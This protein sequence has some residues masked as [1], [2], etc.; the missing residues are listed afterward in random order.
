MSAADPDM[1][2]PIERT[3]VLAF[4]MDDTLFPEFDYVFSGFRA[5]DLWLRRKREVLGFAEAAAE[6]YAMG[7]RGTVFDHAL[8][9]MGVDEDKNL[10]A[11]MVQVYR[12]HNPDIHLDSRTQA[13]LKALSARAVLCLISDGPLCSQRAKAAALGLDGL[14]DH[15]RCTDEWGREFWKPSPRAFEEVAALHPMPTPSCYAYIG[16]NPSKD[17]V[18]PRKM[19][20]HS[21]RFIRNRGMHEHDSAPSTDHEPDSVIHG[22]DDLPDALR[23][24]GMDV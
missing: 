24:L 14:F 16:D 9:V 2:P 21:V 17:F 10:V 11:E 12:C 13:V 18:I 3:C 22:M 8:N 7:V 1:P 5:V 15:I 4:D 20:W 23:A 6:A 19:G